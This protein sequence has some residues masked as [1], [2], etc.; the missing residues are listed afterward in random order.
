MTDKKLILTRYREGVLSLTMNRNRIHDISYSKEHDSGAIGDIYVAKILHVV[1]SIHAAFLDYL[2]GKKGYLPISEKYK[3]V[4]LN[5]AYDGRILAGDEI[6]VQLEKEAIRTKEPVFTMNLSLAGKYC[7]VTN[8]DTK[9]SV[10]GKLTRQDREAL[11]Q[12][13]P[14]EEE[15]PYGIVIRTNAKELLESSRLSALEAECSHLTAQMDKL[16]TEGIHRTCYSRIYQAASEYLLELR[17]RK[18]LEYDNIVTDD[19]ALYEELR[20]FLHSYL[21]EQEALLSLYCDDDFSLFKLYGLESKIEELMQPKVW[22]KSGA[23]LVI[24]QTEAMYVI[25]VNSGKNNTKKSSS[26]YIHSINMEAAE[27][28]MRQIH[29]RNLSGIIIVDFINI[30]ENEKKEELL[31]ELRTLARLDTIQTTIVDMTPLGLMEI[32]RKKTKRSLK[33]QL[34]S[35]S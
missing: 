29:L 23:Y 27:E 19:P 12:H 17:D 8:A 9:K 16:L 1:P 24:E 22:L 18:T 6:L 21:P 2:P 26:A 33:A 32:T 34:H 4:L 25:D 7:V 13:L 15:T 14:T 30:E 10:S 5:R 20:D 31:Q 3:P 35:S 11:R 28:I